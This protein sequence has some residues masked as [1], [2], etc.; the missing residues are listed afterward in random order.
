M[1]TYSINK[2][3]LILCLVALIFPTIPVIMRKGFW[4]KETLLNFLLLILF[5]FPAALHAWYVIYKTSNLRSD[6]EYDR[7]QGS[8][9]SGFASD[10]EDEQPPQDQHN[11]V[12]PPA[13]AN[14]TTND[15][16]DNKNH[17]GFP[18]D[19]KVQH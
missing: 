11:N 12:A 1:S 9:E 17:N 15:N 10:E 4:T 2:D 14:V 13:Y 3:D 16:T 8:L 7:L 6:E 19:N 18:L 5:A